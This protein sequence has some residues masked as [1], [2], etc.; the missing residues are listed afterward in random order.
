MKGFICFINI[1][2]ISTLLHFNVHAQIS[3]QQLNGRAGD[4]NTITTAVPFLTIAPDSRAGAMG[5]PHRS[6][7]RHG[8]DVP[9][10][11]PRQG[12]HRLRVRRR[13][14]R[15]RGRSGAREPR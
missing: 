9:D 13:R 3:S 4:V 14:A 12:L 10:A 2:T 7:A 1:L 8:Q 11:L 5:D 6:R 15:A